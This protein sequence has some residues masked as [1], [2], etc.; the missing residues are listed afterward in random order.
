MSE[1]ILYSRIKGEDRSV[2]L[3]TGKLMVDSISIQNNFGSTTNRYIGIGIKNEHQIP[4]S[5]QFSDVSLNG[6]L[7]DSDPFIQH[8]GQQPVNIFILKD[9][10]APNNNFCLISGYLTS[11][12]AQFGINQIPQIS[13]SFKF[14]K[15]SGPINMNALDNISSGQLNNISNNTYAEVPSG[16][17]IPYGSSLSLTLDEYSSNRVQEFNINLNINRTPVYNIGTRYPRR[18][19]LLYPIEARCSFS[20]ES[21]PFSGINLTGF[22]QTRNTQTIS[23]TVNGQTGELITNYSFPNMALV[24]ESITQTIDNNQLVTREY[25]GY[26]TE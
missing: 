20:F 6:Y 7:I 3:N 15:N 23:L 17:E 12:S 8:T 9:K 13:T 10:N 24:N 4:N 2:F 1:S 22:P 19:D 11:Y 18:V 16:L 21:G 26:L 14:Y 25:V 5:E